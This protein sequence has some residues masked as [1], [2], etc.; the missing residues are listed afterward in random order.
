MPLFEFENIPEKEPMPGFYGRFV[1]TENNTHAFWR[2]EEGAEAPEHNHPHEQSVM[3]LEGELDLIVAGETMR[4][5]P[6]M[7]FV[8]AGDVPHSAKAVTSCTV[9]DVFYPVRE[10]FR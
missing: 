6:G 7:V 4:L 3:V 10:D 2:I 9:L 8:I 5:T 1:H